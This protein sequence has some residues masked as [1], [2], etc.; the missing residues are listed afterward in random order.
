MLDI[1]WTELLII[2]VVAIIVVGPKD[3]P[4][5]L[6]SLGQYAAKLR[7]TANEFRSQFD[8]VLRES[9]LDD[10]KSSIDSISGL[11]PVGQIRDAVNE[12]LDPLKET[13]EEIRTG[14][15][16][17][18]AGEAAPGGTDIPAEENWTDDAAETPDDM[19]GADETVGSDA[20]NGARSNEFEDAADEGARADKSEA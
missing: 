8:E 1:G 9:E 7:R 2:A 17:N 12:S 16:S 10:L 6:R 15:E 3:L 19:A 13:A 20:S 14:I 18:D 11:N 5:M 4:R